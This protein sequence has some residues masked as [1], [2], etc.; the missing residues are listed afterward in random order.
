MITDRIVFELAVEYSKATTIGERTRIGR[1]IDIM[2][3]GMF[4][5][6]RKMLDNQYFTSERIINDAGAEVKRL[7][8]IEKGDTIEIFVPFYQRVFTCKYVSPLVEMNR[9]G[10]AVIITDA[11]V[12]GS[13]KKSHFIPLYLL[14]GVKKVK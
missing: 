8:D 6:T 4:N 12:G 1:E 11:R 10:I 3:E 2:R 5:N 14:D 13:F 9:I 7:H